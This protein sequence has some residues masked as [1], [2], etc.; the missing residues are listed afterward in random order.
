M[1]GLFGEVM[2]HSAALMSQELLPTARFSING[3]SSE[4]SAAPTG[5]PFLRLWR[6]LQYRF[7]MGAGVKY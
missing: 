1:I 3:V 6:Y 4:G 7:N 2:D 5:Q